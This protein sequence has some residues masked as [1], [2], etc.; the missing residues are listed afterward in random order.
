MDVKGR[1]KAGTASWIKLSDLKESNPIETAEYAVSRKIDQEPVFVWRASTTLK[2]R[3][4]I[5]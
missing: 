3:S 5:F 1:W 4:D 2:R